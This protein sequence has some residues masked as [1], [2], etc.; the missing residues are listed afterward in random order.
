ME[1]LFKRIEANNIAFIILNTSNRWLGIALVILHVK[2]NRTK[3]NKNAFWIIY[4]AQNPHHNNYKESSLRFYF[5][6]ASNHNCL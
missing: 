2:F 6:R 4:K 1:M 5:I 3:L